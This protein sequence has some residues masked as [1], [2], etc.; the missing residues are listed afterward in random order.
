MGKDI[1]D[2]VV[3]VVVAVIFP[4]VDGMIDEPLARETKGLEEPVL[5]LELGSPDL[6]VVVT[7]VDH[8]NLIHFAQGK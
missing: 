7:G 8:L 3:E 1:T 6:R 5:C 2:G 4:L